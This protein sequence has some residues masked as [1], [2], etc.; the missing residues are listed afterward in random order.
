[1]AV[2]VDMQPEA[3]ATPEVTEEIQGRSLTAIAWGRF[4]RDKVGMWALGALI[5]LLLIALFAPQITA[6]MAARSWGP[7]SHRVE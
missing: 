1:M 5:F 3:P 6:A 7:Q 4:R 2:P